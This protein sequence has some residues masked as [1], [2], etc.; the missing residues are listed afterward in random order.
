MFTLCADTQ[1]KYPSELLKE[2]YTASFEKSTVSTPIVQFQRMDSSV[3]E[4]SIR[5]LTTAIHETIESTRFDWEDTKYPDGFS[6]KF[7]EEYEALPLKPLHVRNV[8]A[9]I[10]SR[11]IGHLDFSYLD[12]YEDLF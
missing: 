10:I 5:E 12:E 1:E 4:D 11:E 6:Y 2:L 9:N 7:P 3:Y 8:K